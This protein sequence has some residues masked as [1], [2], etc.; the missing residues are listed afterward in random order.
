MSTSEVSINNLESDAELPILRFQRPPPPPPTQS[1]PSSPTDI[2]TIPSE[3]IFNLSI[4]SFL[5]FNLFLILAEITPAWTETL[6]EPIKDINDTCPLLLSVIQSILISQT[7]F[8]LI[9]RFEFNSLFDKF[10]YGIVRNRILT[11]EM[12]TSPFTTVLWRIFLHC[13]PRDSSHWDQTIDASR[14]QYSE[15][16][17]AYPLDSR[18][19][20]ELN[21]DTEDPN[22]PLSQEEKV[23]KSIN[24][25]LFT[26]DLFSR[27]FGIN[28]IYIK[29]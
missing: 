13:L 23:I 6:D 1:E 15:L 29:D 14:E 28:I 20:G 21:G 27:V 11:R 4:C 17:D 19:I 3:S 5:H 7:I 24:Q 8:F 16:A 25:L 2:I 9:S 22:H 10:D 18:K 26:L 12:T